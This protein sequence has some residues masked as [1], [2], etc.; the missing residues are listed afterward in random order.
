MI[1]YGSCFTTHPRPTTPEGW[2]CF[3]PT[4]GCKQNLPSKI[5]QKQPMW[6]K[7]PHVLGSQWYH[8]PHSGNATKCN[9]KSLSLHATPTC[10]RLIVEIKPKPSAWHIYIQK[11]NSWSKKYTSDSVSWMIMNDDASCSM[12]HDSISSKIS[13]R[14]LSTSTIIHSRSLPHRPVPAQTAAWVS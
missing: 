2:I 8:M 9:K 5:M 11:S 12:H 10:Q 4:S 14:H 7:K 13:T 1:L 3:S 6:G